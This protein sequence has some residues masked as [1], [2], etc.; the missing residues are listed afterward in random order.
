MW[1]HLDETDTSVRQQSVRELLPKIIPLFYPHRRFL[2]A[3]YGLLL[4]ITACFLAGP[5]LIQYIIDNFLNTENASVLATPEPERVQ[6]LLIAAGI[7]VLV[8]VTFAS[9]G[10]LQG[11]TLFRL[12]INIVT[13]ALTH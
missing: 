5:K 2:L 4:I 1:W 9:V 12:G 6:G 10:Y 7:Y 8:A 11:I 13:Y 3:G